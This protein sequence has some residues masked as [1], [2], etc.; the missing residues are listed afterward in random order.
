MSRPTWDTP[1]LHQDFAYRTVTFSGRTFQTVPL[2]LRMP[3]RGPATPSRKRDGLGCSAFARRY[4]RNHRLF[5]FPRGTE[6]FHFPRYRPEALCIQT[7]VTRHYSGWVAPFGHPRI[8]ACLPLPGAY[9]SLPRPS[10]PAG[11]KASIV[12]PYA[13]DQFKPDLSTEVA[14]PSLFNCQRAKKS[15]CAV[16]PPPHGA[17]PF[18]AFAAIGGRAWNRTRDL[19]LIRDAL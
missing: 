11:T 19:I 7:P 6:M 17:A 18:A 3:Y 15:L 9:R 12:C 13:L 4:L 1:R 16:G 2:S 14:C 5:S 10:S 8:S